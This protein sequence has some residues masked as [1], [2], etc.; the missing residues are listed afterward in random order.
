MNDKEIILAAQQ[1]LHLE[2]SAVNDLSQ[3]LGADFCKVV[4]AIVACKSK[5]VFSGIG[6]SGQIARKLAS[7]FSST[8]SPAIFLHMAEAMHGDF[9]VLSK[10]DLLIV[11]SYSGEGTDLAALLKY[12]SRKAI[13]LVAITGNSNSILAK[14]S[15]WCLNIQVKQEACPLGLAPTCSS[16]VSLALGDALAVAALELR[17]FK[18]ENFAELHPGGSLGRRLLTKVSDLMHTKNLPFVDVEENFLSVM[19]LMTSS[20][21]R[22]VV[23]VLKNS[24]LVGVI[25]DGDIRI[26]L[27]KVT[28][29]IRSQKAKDIM[30]TSPKNI[31]FNVLAEEALHAMEQFK[32]QALFVYSSASSNEVN[33]K[34]VTL[35][36][37][38]LQVVG[39]IHLQDLLQAKIL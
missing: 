8:G 4:K 39:L 10:E 35:P 23:G 7:T 34:G 26:F 38:A 20:K 28:G 36:D 2:A 13:K 14:N 18:K 3:T 21:V 5:I 6:K 29:D 22:G 1:V 27:Q 11:I 31:A 9:G 17:G 32:I 16:T 12:A 30:S 24:Q 25:T 15:S 37:K 19:S 33:A